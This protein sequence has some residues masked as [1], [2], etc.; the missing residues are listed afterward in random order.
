MKFKDTLTENKKKRKHLRGSGK[1]QRKS[2]AE[3]KWKANKETGSIL[4]EL[5]TWRVVLTD[6]F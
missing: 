1:Q 4:R 6:E 2:K 3:R 5:E